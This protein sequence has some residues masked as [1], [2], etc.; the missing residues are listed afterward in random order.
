MEAHRLPEPAGD[1]ALEL[2]AEILV[3][4]DDPIL[5]ELAHARL[6]GPG[7]RI[8]DA[9]DGQSAWDMLQE[10]TFSLAVVD[11]NMPGLNGFELIGHMRA[12]VAHRHTPVVV[13]TSLNDTASIERAFAAG[14]TAFVTKPI[15]WTLLTHEVRY[16]L[17][18]AKMEADLR[19][20]RDDA[21]ELNARKDSF[22]SIM[23]HELRTPLNAIIGFAEVLNAQ[24][25]LWSASPQHRSY[26]QEILN[27]G[28]RLLGTLRDLFLYSRILSKDLA[29]QDGEYS[30][31]A[32]EREIS[33]SL[34]DGG[35]TFGV[36]LS[37]QGFDEDV[38]LRCDLQ[39]LGRA[40][41][42]L[43]D[44]AMKFSPADSE[45]LVM[46]HVSPS[47][48]VITIRDHGP[49]IAL[50]EVA[51]YLEPFSQSDM[52]LGRSAEGLGLGLTIANAL[53]RLHGGTLEFDNVRSGLREDGTHDSGAIVRI[54]LP[55][56]RVSASNA[57]SGCAKS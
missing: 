14:A 42:G 30:L 18:A 45:V 51:N 34:A 5:R 26:V 44:N 8:A 52:S 37:M 49:G 3:V 56:E 4:D 33:S 54:T 2:D 17:R 27:G 7:W 46:A 24:A 23:S 48:L 40:L 20:A 29:L 43:V 1:G 19:R 47:G 13:I 16:V 31:D 28:H 38:P 6:G 57:S 39:L 35:D 9:S 12:S 21:Q 55:A 10:R 22:L 53:V 41:V 36:A 50:E 25:G 11:L 15:N 32:V